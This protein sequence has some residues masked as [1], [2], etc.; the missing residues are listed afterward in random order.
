M[1]R[2]DVVFRAAQK[3][4]FIHRAK[5]LAECVSCILFL[6]RC[7][8]KKTSLDHLSVLAAELGKGPEYL[9]LDKVKHAPQLTQVVLQRGSG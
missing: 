9:R 2:E 1:D 3:V 4:T 6:S 8:F 5:L 7:I